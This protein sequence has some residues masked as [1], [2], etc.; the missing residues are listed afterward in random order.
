MLMDKKYNDESSHG[1]NGYTF[2]ETSPYYN[3]TNDTPIVKNNK[4]SRKK[5]NNEK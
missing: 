3:T 2:N 4:G 5:H 1:N